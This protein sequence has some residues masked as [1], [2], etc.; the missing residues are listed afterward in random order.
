MSRFIIHLKPKSFIEIMKKNDKL[1][2][3]VNL[4]SIIA[5]IQHELNKQDE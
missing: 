2:C 5:Q 1:F 3:V 4:F